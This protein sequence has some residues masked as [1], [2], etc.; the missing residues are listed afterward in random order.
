MDGPSAAVGSG[1]L[2][3]GSR[4]SPFD[5]LMSQST[6]ALYMAWIPSGMGVQALENSFRTALQSPIVWYMLGIPEE[7]VSE[8]RRPYL[9]A[10]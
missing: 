2:A 4:T 5:T 3:V 1:A 9:R 7:P 6:A 10:G 8:T